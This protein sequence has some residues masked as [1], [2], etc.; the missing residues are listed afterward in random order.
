VGTGLGRDV[1]RTVDN[2]PRDIDNTLIE[3]SEL[4]KST[5]SQI[6]GLANN[7]TGTLV[8]NLDNNVLVVLVVGDLHT[9]VTAFELSHGLRNNLFEY[10]NFLANISL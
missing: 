10:N 3:A 2:L 8:N 4:S 9:L 5:R 1:V 6:N 7:T